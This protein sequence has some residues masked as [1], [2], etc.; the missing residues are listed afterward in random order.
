[1]PRTNGSFILF[2]FFQIVRAYGYYKK[3]KYPPHTG[4]LF[5]HNNSFWN[6]PMVRW[7]CSHRFP[8][9]LFPIAPHVTPYVSHIFCPKAYTCLYVSHIL[10]PKVFFSSS[11]WFISF[12]FRSLYVRHILCPKVF[13]SS[14]SWF[15]SFPF[16][17][18]CPYR[19]ELR[20]A[21]TFLYYIGWFYWGPNRRLV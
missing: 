18:H 15:I 16:R 3:I 10:C 2:F 6:Q 9:L 21:S 12:P 20:E 17:T 8:K 5:V 14:S 19:A 7:I 4:I 1:M 13:F 11:S